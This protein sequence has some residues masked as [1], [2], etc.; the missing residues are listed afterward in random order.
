VRILILLSLMCVLGCDEGTEP[1]IEP[2]GDVLMMETTDGAL[3]DAE[4]EPVDGDVVPDAEVTPDAELPDADL[5][6]PDAEV[7]EPDA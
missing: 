2:S 3:P 5:P 1:T 4:P 6:E 7:V